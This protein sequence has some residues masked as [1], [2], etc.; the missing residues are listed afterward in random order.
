[1]RLRIS[2]LGLF[3]GLLAITSAAAQNAR[4]D[5]LNVQREGQ[6]LLVSFELVDG[7]DEEMLARIESGL[8]TELEYT[9]RL[10][11]PRTWWFDRLYQRG[12]LNIV[13]KYDAVTQEYQLNYRHDDRLIDSRVVADQ[14]ALVQ[15]M[16]LIT[17][18]PAFEVEGEPRPRDQVM[19]RAELGSKHILL[20]FPN[21]IRTNWA[22]F[23]L[24]SIDGEQP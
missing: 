10:E 11:R 12:R 23:R 6:R 19:V 2:L 17:S 3:L 13:V 16:T 14:A 24:T 22:R 5:G 8:P 7:V 21:R 9:L 1:V 20:L 15:A 18:L 4:I